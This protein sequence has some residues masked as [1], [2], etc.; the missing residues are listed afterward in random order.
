MIDWIWWV[1]G[2]AIASAAICAAWYWAPKLLLTGHVTEAR[3]DKIRTSVAQFVAAISVII[4][5]FVSLYQFQRNQSSQLDQDMTTLFSANLKLLETK[6]PSDTA[7]RAGAI[8]A[9][10]TVM[11]Y[12]PQYHLSLIHI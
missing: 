11:D 2:L 10:Q 5:A 9:M 7:M 1:L 4:G 12:N 6:G 8:Y 3:K